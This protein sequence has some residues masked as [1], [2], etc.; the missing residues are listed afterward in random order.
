MYEIVQVWPRWA[1]NRKAN[2][3]QLITTLLQCSSDQMIMN[4]R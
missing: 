4:D 1:T 3:I 2:A